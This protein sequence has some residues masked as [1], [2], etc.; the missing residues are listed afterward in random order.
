MWLSTINSCFVEEMRE[1]K[2]RSQAV[3]SGKVA[4]ITRGSENGSSVRAVGDTKPYRSEKTEDVV[5]SSGDYYSKLDT[6]V[7]HGQASQVA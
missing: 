5:A 3:E 1:K 4:L 7:S 2:G 6:I